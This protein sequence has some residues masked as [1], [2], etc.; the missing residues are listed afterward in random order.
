MDPL[1]RTASAGR[2]IFVTSEVAR[3]VLPY[4]GPY[5]VSK[6]GLEVLVQLYAGEISKT[7]IRANLIDPGVVR[8][9]LRARAVPGENPVHLPPPESV[10]DAFLALALP[11]CTSNGRLV[12]LSP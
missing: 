5:A 7:R 9:R 11:E 2:A 12:S 3:R 10:T 6:A 8:T 4:W 1:L